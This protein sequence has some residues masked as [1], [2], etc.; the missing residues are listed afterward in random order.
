MQHKNLI[1]TTGDSVAL[2]WHSQKVGWISSY[3][4]LFRLSDLGFLFLKLYFNFLILRSENGAMT[5]FE[6]WF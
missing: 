3:H 2:R 1:K 5:S 4:T 6:R